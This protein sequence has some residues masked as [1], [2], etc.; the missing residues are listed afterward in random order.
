MVRLSGEV[1]RCRIEQAYLLCRVCVCIAERSGGGGGPT[2]CH[3]RILSLTLAVQ[4]TGAGTDIGCGGEGRSSHPPTASNAIIIFI[5]FALHGIRHA[6]QDSIQPSKSIG[7]RKL[8]STRRRASSISRVTYL[9]AKYS[10]LSLASPNWRPTLR[11]HSSP[12]SQ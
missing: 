10:K 8:S 6:A 4:G 11:V 9:D 12:P 1:Q 5:V 3:S 2:C 7:F